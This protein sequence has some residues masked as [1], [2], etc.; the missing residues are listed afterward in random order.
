MGRGG[1]QPFT[2]GAVF[3]AAIRQIMT[4]PT[5]SLRAGG[6]LGIP[7]RKGTTLLTGS[8]AFCLL[9][10]VY[11]LTFSHHYDDALDTARQMQAGDLQ[12][13]FEFRHPISRLMAFWFWCGLGAAGMHLSAL[14]ALQITD[15]VSAAFAVLLVFALL[16]RL[17][18]PRGVAAVAT[19]ACA[20]AWAFWMYAGTG[21]PYST[22]LGFSAAAYLVAASMN[23]DI[24]ERR[25]LFRAAGAGALVMLSCLFWLQ[26]FTNC[27]GVGLLVCLRP[28]G[29]SLWRRAGYLSAFAAAGLLFSL[30]ILV[31]GFRYTGVV[32]SPA[33]IH[34]WIA[35]T[36]TAPVKFE[37][38]GV[39]KAAFGQAAGII[40]I[41]SLPYMIN[42]L[43]RHDPRLLEIGSF[44]WQMSKF[45]VAWILVAPLYLYPLL[46]FP[47]AAPERRALLASFFLA[48]AVNMAFALAWLGSD[49]QRFQPSFPSLAV[50]GAIGAASLLEHLREN[51]RWRRMAIAAILSPIIFVAGVNLFEGVLR[52]QREFSALAQEMEQARGA[53]N[54][55]D[56][57]IFFGRDFSVTYHTMVSY[58]LGP[59]FIDLNDEASLRW[60][61]TDWVDQLNSQIQPVLNRGG[62]VFVVD[63]LV[64]GVNPVSAAWSEVQRPYPKVKDIAVYLRTRFCV[65]PAWHIGADSYW[66]VSPH[67]PSCAAPPSAPA[68]EERP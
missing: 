26:Q 14:S 50:L 8:A 21:R 42:G 38:S 56:F 34:G 32:H 39:M 51:L 63:R 29:R 18:A 9:L 23:E 28:D 20:T 31:S 41:E 46:A 22:A 5:A 61:R 30:L 45:V 4:G 58:Y 68:V 67:T 54:E 10:L 13:M 19:F 60:D 33:D 48:L 17:E 52:E 15:F 11:G 3:S 65:T 59:A 12:A 36:A 25:R 7:I 6:A 16:R 1:Q 62:R 35:S 66:Q 43:L 47:R 37:A 40:K 49:Q 27:L 24:S 64:L 2:T 53:A 55:R 44:P 57:V